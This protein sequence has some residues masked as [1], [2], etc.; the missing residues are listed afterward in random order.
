MAYDTAP[1]PEAP[2]SDED[3]ARQWIGE[4]DAAEKD[5]VRQKWIGR[6]KV[7]LEVYT[8]SKSAEVRKNKRLALFWSNVE[9]LKPAIWARTPAAVVTRRF[10][11]AD[12]VGRVASE[13]LER[14][15]NFT[16]DA[17]DF[18]ST[19]LGCRDEFLLFHHADGDPAA[20]PGAAAGH[21]RRRGRP[22]GGRRRCGL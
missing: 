19:M 2:P 14:S 15:L 13:V 22:A 20:G 9:T 10:K 7:I 18:A 3:L 1:Q 12:P 5:P 6:C 16:L 8:D 17:V 4:L 21:H 11:D